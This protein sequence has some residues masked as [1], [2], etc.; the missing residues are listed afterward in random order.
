LEGDAYNLRKADMRHVLAACL[1]ER[2]CLDGS[3]T[4]SS[5]STGPPLLPGLIA[6]SI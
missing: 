3:R 6:A 4:L 2:S 1:R 5:F